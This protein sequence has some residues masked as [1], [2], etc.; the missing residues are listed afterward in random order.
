M[1]AYNWLWEEKGREKG[2]VTAETYSN[3]SPT[4]SFGFFRFFPM[5]TAK[6][7]DCQIARPDP[8][9]VNLLRNPG[10][11]IVYKCPRFSYL[12][13]RDDESAKP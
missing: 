7:L 9:F 8:V 1:G 10:G 4:V 3:L 5:T 13:N 6:C 2:S 11:M 12:S